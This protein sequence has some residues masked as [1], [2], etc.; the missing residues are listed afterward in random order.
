VQLLCELSIASATVLDQ[1]SDKLQLNILQNRFPISSEAIA[2][3]KPSARGGGDLKLLLRAIETRQRKKGR[4]EPHQCEASS[5]SECVSILR[6]WN[7][8]ICP[9]GAGEGPAWGA[10]GLG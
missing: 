2:Y 3:L 8:I 1:F 7:R 9:A 10:L 4:L 5:G 6:P